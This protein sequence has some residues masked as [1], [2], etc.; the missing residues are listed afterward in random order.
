MLSVST[1]VVRSALGP[2]W[3]ACPADVLR[4]LAA[5]QHC[6]VAC[7]NSLLARRDGLI[8][9]GWSGEEVLRRCLAFSLSA[10]P[11]PH[12]QLHF[13]KLMVKAPRLRG[14]G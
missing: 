4:D 1:A 12:P 11:Q 6:S 7:V 14:V 10:A 5:A 3:S 8:S 13:Y 9:P 2:K